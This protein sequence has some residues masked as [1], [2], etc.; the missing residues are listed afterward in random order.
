MYLVIGRSIRQRHST[1]AV[2]AP[3]N[4]VAAVTALVVSLGAGVPLGL[5]WPVVGLCAVM[6]IGPGLIGHG[7]MA[8]AMR[9]LP[10]ATLGLLGLAEPLLSSV[11]AFVL[12]GEVPSAL[13]IGGMAFVLAAIA[14]VVSGG[15]ARV[16]RAP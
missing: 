10:A 15:R 11:L 7:S 14:V 1:L 4:V 16:L 6:A 9:Y 12:F 8:V 3:V 13:S 5:P 2:F